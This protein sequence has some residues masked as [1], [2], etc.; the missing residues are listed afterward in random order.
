MFRP[1]RFPVATNG[2]SG[3]AASADMLTVWV[4]V[5]AGACDSTAR[6]SQPSASSV[7]YDDRQIARSGCRT[8]RAP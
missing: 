1:Q 3:I 5:S 7:P 4:T 6:G 2:I 8:R